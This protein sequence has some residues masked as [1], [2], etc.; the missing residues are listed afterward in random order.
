MRIRPRSPFPLAPLLSL[1]TLLSPIGLGMRMMIS[2]IPSMMI[3]PG[4]S[5]TLSWSFPMGWMLSCLMMSRLGV[6]IARDLMGWTE[7]S[8]GSGGGVGTS[9]EQQYRQ[10]GPRK[11]PKI[12][13]KK[14]ITQIYQQSSFTTTQPPYIRLNNP[15]P[16]N[17]Y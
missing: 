2:L 1:S 8:V 6:V 15:T 17:Q 14:T 13:N 4:S 11:R 5:S 16:P 12:D 3:R 10:R 7:M 9:D